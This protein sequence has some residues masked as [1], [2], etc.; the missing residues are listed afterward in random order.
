MRSTAVRRGGVAATIEPRSRCV[1]TLQAL[2]K[3]SHYPWGL[4]DVRGGGYLPGV[5]V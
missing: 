5:P 2:P 4:L 1:V 3:L